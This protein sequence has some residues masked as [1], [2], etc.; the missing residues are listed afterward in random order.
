MSERLTPTM[1]RALREL[2]EVRLLRRPRE[3]P[4]G[5]S[6]VRA[7]IKR[8]LCEREGSYVRLTP[9]GHQELEQR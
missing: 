5:Q 7:L 2:S 9:Q 6:T 1:R 8:G 4:G 3:V